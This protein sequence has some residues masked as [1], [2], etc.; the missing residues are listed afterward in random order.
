RSKKFK[1]NN[2]WI[3][4]TDNKKKVV[5][6]GRQEDGYEGV[7]AVIGGS[8]THL[9]FITHQ[10]KNISVFN[11]NT[12]QFIKHDTLPIDN[13]IYSPCFVS[14]SENEQE[15]MK[16][17]KKNKNIKML[18][19][20]KKAGLSIRY[21][22]TNNT[23]RYYTKK[24]CKDIAPFWNYG[25]V[26]INDII[27]FFGG[28]SVKAISNSVYKYSI[29]EKKWTTFQDALPTSLDGCVAMSSK[30]CKNVHI[31]GV[32]SAN[33]DSATTHLKTKVRKWLAEEEKMKIKKQ[34]SVKEKNKKRK[35]ER[36][37]GE[38]EEKEKEK[39]E[40]GEEIEKEEK[41]KEKEEQKK[42]RKKWIKWLKRSDKKDKKEIVT[43][44]KGSKKDFKMWL[45]DQERWKNDLTKENISVFYDA[46]GSFADNYSSDDENTVNSMLFY[47]NI[48]SVIKNALVVMIAISEY[49]TE[50]ENLPNVKEKDIKHFRELF[51]DE[52][53][54]KFVCKEP[55]MDK[56]DV[57]EFLVNLMYKLLKNLSNYDALILIICG[58]GDAGNALV[59]SEGESISIDTIRSFFDRERLPSFKD[60]PKIFFIDI[61]RGNKPFSIK[62]IKKRGKEGGDV[63]N[64]DGFLIVW[65]TTSGYKVDDLSLFSESIKDTIIS[66]YENTF[67]YQM[68]K[69]VRVNVKGKPDSSTYCV[70][71]SDTTDYHIVLEKNLVRFDFYNN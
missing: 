60:Y 23:F 69:E 4:F 44:F 48:S 62:S 34:L 58:H 31:I 12:F 49:N 5:K 25:Y 19:F 29:R 30:D 53:N 35:E 26:R 20:H 42:E 17:N 68:L 41:E 71:I 56:Q 8:N 43:K 67:L 1:K 6:L 70:E 21:D 65:S 40:E 47:S 55:K 50:C 11:L 63:H 66:K 10:P 57:Q 24:V 2:Q 16:G 15:M 64:D 32:L 46:V 39:E 37:E 18:L 51:K 45:L 14:T 54:Y 13:E 36:E 22:E 38:E 33:W 3:P 7:R 52:L 59:T 28:W 9:L 61:C 27:L